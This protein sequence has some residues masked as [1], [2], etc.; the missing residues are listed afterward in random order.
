MLNTTQQLMSILKV[1]DIESKYDVNGI[2]GL[3]DMMRISQYSM[4]E[5][6]VLTKYPITIRVCNSHI[7]LMTPVYQYNVSKNEVIETMLR[8]I[9]KQ[10]NCQFL[11]TASGIFLLGLDIYNR[12][13]DIDNIRLSIIE[14]EHFANNIRNQI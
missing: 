13:L 1:E 14:L 6:G 10:N 7:S 5:M 4:R 3:I 8:N 12:Y 2:D 11:R 9:T